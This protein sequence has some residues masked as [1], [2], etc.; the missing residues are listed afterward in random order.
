MPGT[1]SP[2]LVRLAITRLH[3][4]L[5]AWRDVDRCLLEGTGSCCT[6]R[7]S[8]TSWPCPPFAQEAEGGEEGRAFGGH[9]HA[10]THK[11]LQGSGGSEEE[12]EGAYSSESPRVSA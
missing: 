1:S 5:H 6:C 2:C 9:A 10:P 3:A 12:E 7:L 4:Q 8:S 11:H